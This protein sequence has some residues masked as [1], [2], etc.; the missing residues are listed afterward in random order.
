MSSRWRFLATFVVFFAMSW[1]GMAMEE[2]H[3]QRANRAA[4]AAT[5]EGLRLRS[6]ADL[7]ST[8]LTEFQ[9]SAGKAW[10]TE[11]VQ[12]SNRL[13]AEV[14]RL[15]A[16]Q[17][18]V[19]NRLVVLLQPWPYRLAWNGGVFAVLAVGV[20]WSYLAIQRERRTARRRAA[21]QCVACGY[22]LRESPERCPECG[23]VST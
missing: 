11:Q 18:V 16:A 14:N 8:R 4:V 17:N 3:R 5:A 21:G 6:E 2:A 7:A 10:T 12:E 22:D 23:T 13:L 9:L 15:Q 1:G 19:S 20:G